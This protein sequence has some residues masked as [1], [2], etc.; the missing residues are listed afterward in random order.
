MGVYRFNDKKKELMMEIPFGSN[1]QD[2][3]PSSRWRSCSRSFWFAASNLDPARRL[4]GQLLDPF[5]AIRVDRRLSLLG[6]SRWG[7]GT[8]S[9]AEIGMVGIGI[10][11]KL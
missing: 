11:H 4:P 8:G 3:F 5:R 1:D 2:P 7:T 6:L 9:R 10:V